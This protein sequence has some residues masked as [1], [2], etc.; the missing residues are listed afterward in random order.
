MSRGMQ[1]GAGPDVVPVA[2]RVWTVR[3]PPSA[4]ADTSRDAN[5]DPVDEPPAWTR[6]R[7]YPA[8][9][10]VFD[11][12]TLD[13]AGQQLMVG[14]W[15]LYRTDPDAPA[16]QVTCIEEGFFYP[17]TCPSETPRDGKRCAATSTPTMLMSP[18]GS[19]RNYSSIRCR[20]G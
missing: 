1:D 14:V 11:T 18:P 10:L 6:K 8:E 7:R 9:V 17:M 5:A 12:E 4:E 16:G 13:G 3:T 2:V 15:R 20:G 19:G